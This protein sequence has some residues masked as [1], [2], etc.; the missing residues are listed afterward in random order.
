[1]SRKSM[2]VTGLAMGL[3]LLVCIVTV[4]MLIKDA[5]FSPDKE[6][7]ALVEEF[8][9][10]EQEGEF[11][12]SWELFH[13]TM[14][15]KFSK[16]A[17]IQDRA[18]VFMNHFGVETFDFTISEPEQ[19]DQWKMSK[20]GP[21]MKNVYKILVTQTYKGKYGNFDLEQEV[22]ALEEKDEWKIVWDYN[23]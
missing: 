22:I 13:S 16:G 10:Y 9:R 5:W 11:A 20:T 21:V 3:V 15:G 14:K 23:Q 2:P 8:Y 18:H 1:M 12:S 17:Y 6:A 19:I 7:F 4:F